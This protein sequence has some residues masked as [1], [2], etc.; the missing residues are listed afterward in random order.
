MDPTTTNPPVTNTPVANTPAVSTPVMTTPVV[1]PPVTNAPVVN[2]PLPVSPESST[3]KWLIIGI[4]IVVI[5]LIIGGATYF[6]MTSPQL[7]SSL[8]GQPANVTPALPAPPPPAPTVPKPSPATPSAQPQLINQIKLTLTTP[9]DKATVTTSNLV[10]SGQTVPNADVSV[11]ETDLK[12]DA[13][14]NFRTTVKL[15]EGDNPVIVDAFDTVGNSAEQEV[16][17]TYEPAQ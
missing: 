1:N 2:P 4:V 3:N 15:D 9:V 16:T 6:V 5:V 12:A 17:V 14:G 11:N 13:Q 7:L 10:V 8:T